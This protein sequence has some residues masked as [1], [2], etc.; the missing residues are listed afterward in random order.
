MWIDIVFSGGGV[1]GFAFAG[2]LRQLEKSGYQFKRAAGTSAGSMIAALL[3]AGYSP[4]ELETVVSQM[5][6]EKLLDASAQNRFPFIKW[7]RMYFKMG[8]YRGDLLEQWLTEM[9]AQKG[10]STFSDLPDGALKVVASDIS[11]GKMVV[12]PN[13]L[14]DYGVDPKTFSVARAV[15]MSAGLPLFFEPAALFDD[16]GKRS[17]IVDGGILSNFPIWIFD[18]EEGLPV[19]PFLGLRI[20]DGKE[21]NYTNVKNAAE[22]FRGIF[23]AMHNAHDERTTDKL[24]DSNIISI[25]VTHVETRDMQIS[26]A[27]RKRLCRIGAEE[28]RRF[29]QKWSF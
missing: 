29:L 15:R 19:R 20:V 16:T 24:K 2:A 22:L 5:D 14:V 18:R 7:L 10:V 13:D 4:S 21:E 9:L 26:V 3:M 6:T 12:F 25:P 1:K 28:T 23:T 11:R 17:L 8:L 27:E